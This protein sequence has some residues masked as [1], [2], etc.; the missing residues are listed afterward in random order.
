MNIIIVGDVKIGL[1]D[2][3]RIYGYQNVTDGTPSDYDPEDLYIF[4]TQDSPKKTN[5]VRIDI[6]QSKLAVFKIAV[7]A[8][9]AKI[10]QLSSKTGT[11]LSCVRKSETEEQ[12]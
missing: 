4:L 5:C 8:I 7:T 2:L 9:E 3:L 11:D 10:S 1:S 12:K 6:D